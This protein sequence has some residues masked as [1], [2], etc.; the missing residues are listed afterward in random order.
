MAKSLSPKSYFEIPHEFVKTI[1]ET[2]NEIKKNMKKCYY[3]MSRY[4][5]NIYTSYCVLFEFFKKP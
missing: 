3:Y 2:K 1:C 5:L 4:L